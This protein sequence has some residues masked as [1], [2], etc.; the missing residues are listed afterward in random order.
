MP[1]LL[2]IS[3]VF[4]LLSLHSESLLQRGGT[5]CRQVVQ[6]SPLSTRPFP[7][8]CGGGCPISVK[9]H[10]A[11]QVPALLQV[12]FVWALLSLHWVLLVQVEVVQVV[13]QQIVFPPQGES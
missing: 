11:I 3:A 10:V 1:E 4:E 2:Q 8:V 6:V 9:T 13:P 12:S 5:S 7:Q